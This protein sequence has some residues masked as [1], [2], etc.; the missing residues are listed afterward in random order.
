[1]TVKSVSSKKSV[2]QSKKEKKRDTRRK[3]VGGTTNTSQATA[4]TGA[5]SIVSSST[6]SLFTGLQI[7]QE[8]N[9]LRYNPPEYK[10]PPNAAQQAPVR[11]P[12]APVSATNENKE[13][14]Y[15][16]ALLLKTLVGK[17][18][19]STL[20]NAYAAAA[21]TQQPGLTLNKIFKGAGKSKSK[22]KK[23]AS[24]SKKKDTKRR[25]A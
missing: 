10:K 5:T 14:I 15:R 12:T 25:S 13:L 9:P 4:F 11:P 20:K 21:Q 6:P 22:S 8:Y 2:K 24:K 3:Y 18:K 17:N 16:L 23:S 1:M 19:E 7:Y